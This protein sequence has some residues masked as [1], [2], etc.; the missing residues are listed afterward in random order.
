MGWWRA[1]VWLQFGAFNER[2]ISRS[3]ECCRRRSGV[4]RRV[5]YQDFVEVLEVGVF[6]FVI[7]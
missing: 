5:M 3:V 6:S 7:I 4:L 1:D 2:K